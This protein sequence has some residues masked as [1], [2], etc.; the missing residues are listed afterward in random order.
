MEDKNKYN[1]RITYLETKI[2]ECER[3][4]LLSI[5]AILVQIIM[6]LIAIIGCLVK[7]ITEDSLTYMQMFKWS[8]KNFW[9]AYLY[10][11]IYGLVLKEWINT[12]TVEHRSYE[13]QLQEEKNKLEKEGKENNTP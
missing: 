13:R 9:W 11:L 10:M 8:M 1:D 12:N 2:E 3:K 6:Y 5:I 7:W 4:N